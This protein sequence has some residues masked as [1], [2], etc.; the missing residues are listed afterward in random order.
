MPDTKQYA[1]PGQGVKRSQR[2]RTDAVGTGHLL[3][4]QLGVGTDQHVAMTFCDEVV[5]RGKKSAVL[6]DIVGRCSD[7]FVQLGDEAAVFRL[8]PYP[9]GSRAGIATRRAVDPGDGARCDWQAGSHDAV[10]AGK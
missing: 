4:Q 3:Y 9:I 10:A 2:R 7:C 8:D 6:G 1:S 5:Q